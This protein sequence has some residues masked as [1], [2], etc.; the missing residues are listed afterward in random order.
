MDGVALASVLV[1][2]VGGTGVAL[3]TLVLNYRSGE[4][5]RQH[6][7]DLDFRGR[8]WERKSEAL[9]EVIKDC[10]Q[11][12]DTPWS[13]EDSVREEAAVSLSQVLDRLDAQRPTIHALASEDCR[14]GL[15]DL[16]ARLVSAG[17][18]HGEGNEAAKWRARAKELDASTEIRPDRPGGFTAVPPDE[19][20]RLQTKFRFEKW[21]KQHRAEAFKDLTL[22]P[23][24]LA[25]IMDSATA[26]REAARESIGR[27][28][29]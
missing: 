13:P 28:R 5:Q 27:P 7:A 15:H 10:E 21:E 22:P 8:V 17:V 9:F 24:V 6:E 14:N 11:I 18:K 20:A 2:G 3:A 12:V 4:K 29:D 25:D 16:M 19:A 1:T 26:L 23:S